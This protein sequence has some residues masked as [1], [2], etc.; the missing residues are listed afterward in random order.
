MNFRPR[1]IAVAFFVSFAIVLGLAGTGA[2][3]GQTP[4]TPRPRPQPGPQDPGQPRQPQQPQPPGPRTQEDPARPSDVRTTGTGVRISDS[5]RRTDPGA[6]VGPGA[7]D[8]QVTPPAVESQG[9]REAAEAARAAAGVR[10]V[11]TPGPAAGGARA[12]RGAGGAVSVVGQGNFEP[13]LDQPVV[14]A[15]LPD[16][17]EPLTLEGPMPVSEFLQTIHLA[18]DWNILVSEAAKV[19]NL[20]FLINQTS[21]KSAMRILQFNE[22]YY[23]YDEDANFLTVKTVDEYLEETYAGLVLHEFVVSY[24]DVAYIESILS[25]LLS[26]RGRIITDQRT[27]HIYVW[28]TAYNIEQM[29]KTAGD[30]DVELNKREF[31]VQHAELAD[32][33]SLISSMLSANGSIITDART[34]QIFVWDAPTVLARMTETVRRLDVPVASRTFEIR[35][36]SAE[37]VLDGIE[38]L[39]SERGSIQVDPRFNTLVVTDLPQRMDKIAEM[40]SA[41]DRELETRTWVVKYADID[42]IANQIEQHIPPEMGAVVVNDLVHQITVT[43]LPER[44]DKIEALIK[45]WDIKRRQV[46]IEAYLVDMDETVARELNVQWS[47]FANSALTGPI[48]LNSPIGRFPGVGNQDV[49]VGTLPY[50][51]PLYGPLTLENGQITRPLLRDINDQPIIDRFGGNRL[52]MSLNYLDQNTNATVLAAPRV[53]V[54]DGEEA[55]FENARRVPFA[56]SSTAFGNVNF[57]NITSR[58]EFVDVGIILRVRPRVS[59]D[60]NV[61]LDVAAE[62]SSAELID[63]EEVTGTG[64]E[65]GVTTRKAPEVRSRNV[66]T[67]LRV[68][69]GDTVVMGGLR[70]D[71]AA[72]GYNQTPLL[73]DIPVIGRIFRNPRRD[74]SARSLMIFITPTIIDEYTQPESALL[75]RAHD[76]I[77]SDHRYNMKSLWERILEKLNRGANEIGVSIGQTGAIHSEGKSTT[78]DELRDAFFRVG[79]P[80]AVTVV[81]RE[82][83]RAPREIVN[84][85]TEAAMEAGL[86]VEFDDAM[87]PL[88]PSPRPEEAADGEQAARHDVDTSAILVPIAAPAETR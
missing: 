68:Q 7:A 2:G 47:Y 64:G 66:E 51:V 27:N 59:E 39:L 74:S 5:V 4:D 78:I 29:V 11:G 83:P 44:L 63:I 53:T 49:T 69:S 32:I 24:A 81:I 54:Q 37:D 76:R 65:T 79:T 31:T 55:I 12:V 15:D 57:G 56:S 1:R 50:T 60:L 58:V 6:P 34:S 84:G 80:R 40:V 41:L 61:L 88:V 46:M 36:I 14:Y 30:L 20:E 62:D 73:G 71:R 87:V 16:I 9:R 45:V 85:I 70:E 77:A 19:Q 82:H 28:D 42:F 52:A 33:E 72:R 8:P 35:W 17:G 18:T 26:S 38:P 3:Q 21:P 86:R 48:T 25:S 13:A 67:Q 43:G 10:R 75:A 22:I 23:E